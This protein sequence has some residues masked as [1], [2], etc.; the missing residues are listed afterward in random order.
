MKAVTNVLLGN[1]WKHWI[2]I[3]SSKAL[4]P[5]ET[6]LKEFMLGKIERVE[7]AD[8]WWG[9]KWQDEVK[10]VYDSIA[11]REA[12]VCNYISKYICPVQ[13]KQL[14]LSGR[15]EHVPIA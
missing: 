14:T 8:D 1:D 5:S 12:L 2:K 13:Y 15:Y 6:C 4:G 3:Q 11:K 10:L 9:S 7:I